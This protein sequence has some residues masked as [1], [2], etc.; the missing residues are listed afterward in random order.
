[1]KE[2]GFDIDFEVVEWVRCWSRW[3]SPPD[4]PAGKVVDAINCSLSY[5]DP[6][7]LYR[8]PPHRQLLAGELELGS[9]HQPQDR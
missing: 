1:M 5:I 4:A 7:S 2:A 9:F 3:R 6:S 8:L